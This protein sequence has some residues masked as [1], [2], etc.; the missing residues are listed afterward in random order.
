MKVKA[1]EYYPLEK[2]AEVLSVPTAEVNRLREQGK[3]RGFRDG[4]TWKFLKDEIHTYLAESIKSRSAA[5]NGKPAGESDDLEGDFGSA[6]S[7]DLLVEDAA[8]PDD[9]DLISVAPTQPKSDL[10]LAALDHDSDLALAEE[11]H[12]SSMVASKKA[13]PPQESDN[14]LVLVEEEKEDKESSVLGL[15]PDS[16]IHEVD[17]DDIESSIPEASA[18]SPQLGKESS[19]LGLAPDAEIHEVDVDDTESSPQLGLAD[20]SGF[21]MLIAAE[22]EESELLQ[23][24]EEKT[25]AAPIM[26]DEFILEPMVGAMD[27]GD[28]ESSSQVIAIDVG[29]AAAEQNAVPFED[30][31]FEFD[32]FDSGVAAPG[33]AAAAMPAASDPFGVGAPAIP[34][35]FTTPAVSVTPSK[36]PVAAEEEYSTGMLAFL[37]CTL[38]MMLLPIV[39]LI[40]HMMHMW[41]WSDPFPLNSILMGAIAGIF[42]L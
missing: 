13:P 24:D 36:K 23:L 6:S 1:A 12:V 30:D 17:F 31:D 3:L 2:V 42:G 38:V 27:D 5:A 15:A 22:Q 28:S 11:S 8:L 40:D 10:D 26:A 20:D 33:V 18:S 37:I 14:D 25:E 21:D 32:G 41:S 7:F 29:L 9:S 16:E 39:M 34:D 4:G 35:A 19:V